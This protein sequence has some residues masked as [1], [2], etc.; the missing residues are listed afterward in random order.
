MTDAVLRLTERH[1]DDEGTAKY[2]WTLHDGRRVETVFFS[3]HAGPGQ[4][5][6]TQTGCAIGCTFC[7]TAL[8]RP[9]RNLSADE[10]YAQAVRVDEDCRERGLTVPWRFVTLSGMGEPLLNYDNMVEAARRLY[11]W[12]DIEVVS[13]TTSGV[14]PRIYQLADEPTYL[15]LHV[16]LHATSDEVRR[17][18]IPTTRKWGIEEILTAARHFARTRDRRVIVNYLMFE[19]VNDRIEDA[20]RLVDMLEPELF[21][22]HLLLWNEIPGFPFRRID[23]HRVDEFRRLL[24]DA[25]LMAK[26]MPSKGRD[27]QA[28]CGQL[29]AERTA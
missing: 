8:Q 21:E 9:A 24:S 12:T 25:G 28:G 26:P 13:L 17:Q 6:S 7:A 11:E 22:V 16:S 2:L 15:Q 14:V 3:H 1:I 10:I 5:L 23:D 29:L 4:C 20:R 18:L 19:S 27:I